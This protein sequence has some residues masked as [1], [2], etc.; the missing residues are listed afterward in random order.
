MDLSLYLA[1]DAAVAGRRSLCDLVA[2]AI[3]GGVTVVQLRH[4]TA[5]G[6]ELHRLGR[7]LLALTRPRGIPLIVNDRVDIMLAL[8]AEGVHV[9]PGDLPLH[10][11]R[12]LAGAKIVG[13]S[14]N[15]LP[16]LQRAVRE[17]ADY[18]G[19]GPAFR[20]ST[21]QDARGNLGPEG[22]GH[23]AAQAPMP[24]VAIGGINRGNVA[25]LA[26][27][28]LAGV[29]VISAILAAQDP[30][31]AARELRQTWDAAATEARNGGQ[32]HA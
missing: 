16:D 29:C 13:T 1:T 27:C 21:K 12:R 14:V 3:D 30:E 18:I 4:K 7:Q 25:R 23:L 8:D 2:A 19:I 24:A 6:A 31:A 17:G 32:P 5:D 28:D 10:A 22:V 15:N 9:G 11:V 20:T 26:G